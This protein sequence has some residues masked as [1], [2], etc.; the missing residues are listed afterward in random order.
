M[1]YVICPESISHSVYL[2]NRFRGWQ[3]IRKDLDVHA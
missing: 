2:E 3:T 1:V